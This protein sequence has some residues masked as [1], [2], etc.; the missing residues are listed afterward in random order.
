MAV[1]KQ[2]YTVSAPWTSSQLADAFRDAFIGAGLMA[3]WHDS[4]TTQNTVNGITETVQHRVLRI[5]IAA[6]RRYGT[7]YH[8]FAFR[9][10]GKTEYSFAHQ[11]DVAS[12]APTGVAGLD[13][14]AALYKPAGS[15]SNDESHRVF[16]SHVTS[17]TTT[18]TRYTS[19][20]KS[21]FSMFLLKGGNNYF[22]FFFIPPSAAT[23]PFVDLGLNTCGGLM[24]P[25]LSP[26]RD[27]NF[28]SA[29]YRARVSFWHLPLLKSNIFCYGYMPRPSDML[30]S[31]ASYYSYM[32][33]TS[34]APGIVYAGFGSSSSPAGTADA[35]APYSTLAGW[36]SPLANKQGSAPEGFEI[37]LPA[38]KSNTSAY[39]GTDSTPVFSDLPYSI[40]FLDRMPVDFG[41][42]WHYTNSSMEVQDVF[43]VTPGAEEWEIVAHSNVVG[44]N[45]PS[46]LV[47]ARII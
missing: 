9:A 29:A 14:F 4:F 44:T 34:S 32:G 27:A 33:L 19:N 15:S 12:H 40:Y 28:Q 3:S 1:T 35:P 45:G 8:W 26:D 2:N 20:A 22:A 37:A 30:A 24:V 31:S 21:G 10:S 11:W 6:G 25:W 16:G 39:R 7:I 42:A 38:E 36:T 17:T 47:L 5:I 46:P 23:Q 18:L 43:Q 41:I 13:Y